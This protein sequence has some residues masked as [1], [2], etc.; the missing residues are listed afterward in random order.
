MSVAMLERIL[1]KRILVAT[2]FTE[3][4]ER[5]V[6]VG[7][8]IAR[9]CKASVHVLNVAPREGYGVTGVGMLGAAEFARRDARRLESDLLRKGYLGGIDCKITV[10]KGEVLPL[11]ASVIEAE[12]IDL[13]IAG[14]HQRSRLGKL[15]VG[16]VAER[17]FRRS[18]C[19]VLVAGPNL[20]LSH[21]AA[22]PGKVLVP[23]D[24]SRQKAEVVPFAKFLAD[25]LQAHVIF[26]NVI[27][28]AGRE[29]TYNQ[30]RA[31]RYAKSRMRELVASSNRFGRQAEFEVETGEPA[32]VIVRKATEH[33]VDLVMLGVSPPSVLSN[34][35][36]ASTAY[37]VV[38]RAQCPVLTLSRM[39]RQSGRGK[40][41]RM[42]VDDDTESAAMRSCAHAIQRYV[43]LGALVCESGK[44]D[45]RA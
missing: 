36:G 24:L 4:S 14:S 25:E 45:S 29:A 37:R 26:L 32:D 23:V 2:D 8:D 20:S 28:T 39:L 31:I 18:L 30:D 7:L 38:Q 9:Q 3:C 34:R 43:R 13:I 33:A 35:L 10:E 11:I 19:P 41:L 5:A 21:R 40:G 22:F 27:R 15:L 42:Q 6:L 16:S 44:V 12:G 1:F 17:I